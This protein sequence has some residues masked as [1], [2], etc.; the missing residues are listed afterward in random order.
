MIE[1]EMKRIKPPLIFITLFLIVSLIISG[2]LVINRQ[3]L[4][5]D[6][7]DQN[8]IEVRLP[9]N[10]SARQ[11][12]SLLKQNGLI[13]NETVF[14]AYLYQ[15][16][17]ETQ[18][19]A[20]LYTFTRSQS[21]PDL[22]RQISQG[23]VERFS[24]TIPEG[25]TVR[26]IGELLINKQLCTQ[27]Q[28]TDALQAN[29]DYDFLIPGQTG[30][31]RLEGFLF[32]DT[33]S[34]DDQTGAQDIIRMMLER[35]STIWNNEYAA[36]ADSKNLSQRDTVIIAS[37]IEREARVA[38][39][40]KIISG[41]IYNRLQKDMPLQ[42]CSTVIYALGEHREILTYEDIKIDSPYNTYKYPGL[43]PGPIASPGRAAIEAAL[44][45]ETNNYYYFVAKGD[46]SH[47]FS[48]TY[49]EHLEAQ[50]R[51]GQ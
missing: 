22:A 50:Q 39:E 21:I 49:T 20:G 24:F 38:E 43:P 34:I 11:V 42:I 44:N 27:Q 33:Y 45:P 31:Q 19:K 28:W 15:K 14:L 48:S 9:E 30:E 18:L 25:Y 10:S 2:W 29:Y 8:M 3:Y 37:L 41:V 5:V 6:P 1:P 23:Q 46:G 47:Y 17:M 4:P 32:P 36:E 51:Y 12:A 13:R 16:G 26:Q 7:D 35:F 40:R